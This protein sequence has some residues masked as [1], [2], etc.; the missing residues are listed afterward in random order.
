M[1]NQKRTKALMTLILVCGLVLGLSACKST[2]PE[3]APETA[4]APTTP[5][6]PTIEAEPS[7]QAKIED[8]APVAGKAAAESLGDVRAELGGPRELLALI[9][10]LERELDRIEKE[11]ATASR[12]PRLDDSQVVSFDLSRAPNKGPKDAKLQVVVFTDFQC[13][14][15]KVCA[16]TLD[17]LVKE[18]PRDIRLHFMHFPLDQACNPAITRQ[19]N[20]QACLA[21]EAAMAAHAQGKFWEMH[22]YIFDNAKRISQESL[23][24]EAGR[25][26]LRVD[27]FKK[28]LETNQFKDVVQDHIQQFLKVGGRGTPTVYINGRLVQNPRWDNLELSR[29]FIEGLL[30]PEPEKSVEFKKAVADPAGLPTARIVLEDGTVLEDRINE[31][32]RRLK[33]IKLGAGR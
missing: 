15:C 28:A 24:A 33:E 25:L 23:V 11:G 7:P 18:F 13:P 9:T 27:A 21:A 2:S 19:F 22:D 3:P 17:Q 1:K 12:D 32:L 29:Q 30:H 8:N 10:Q 4:E 31:L 16:N 14:F 26:G 20:Q 6:E 5:A